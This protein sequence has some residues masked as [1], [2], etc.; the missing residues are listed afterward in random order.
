MKKREKI[1]LSALL[2][3]LMLSLTGCRMR[4]LTSPGAADTV[5]SEPSD[6][7]SVT[8]TEAEPSSSPEPVDD[9]II[10]NTP[11]DPV[12]GNNPGGGYGKTEGNG[13]AVT[14]DPNGGDSDAVI[15]AVQLG[16]KY[17]VQPQAVRR[18]Y[19]FD[20][21]WTKVSGGECITSETVVTEDAPHTLYAHWKS[22]ASCT[23]YFDGNGG[24]VKA[25]QVE[26]RLGEGDAFG[27]MPVPIR[28]GYDFDGWFTERVGGVQISE[29]DIFDGQS[30]LTL[31][32]HWTY[33]PLKFWSFTLTNKSQQIYLCQQTSLYF[34]TETDNLT[35]INCS[36]ISATGSL[37]IA[38]NRDDPGVTDDWVKAKR[39]AVVVKCVSSSGDMHTAADS[40]A[41]R[42]PEQKIVVVTRQAVSGDEASMLYARLALAKELYSDWY[43]D[44]DLSVV[45]NELGVSGTVIYFK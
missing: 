9:S 23:V 30:D 29:T 17:G 31:Y 36:L 20:G 12:P 38:A 19:S 10:D 41:A 39:P 44:V 22:R 15:A 6:K 8:E 45:A 25:S 42:F 35:Q 3:I 1:M 18:G 27:Q 21:W 14:Y 40:M 2:A 37:N 5:I 33:N 34:E 4:I 32:A 13:I 7:A 26:L 11:Q 28:E 16:E 24:R 43:T